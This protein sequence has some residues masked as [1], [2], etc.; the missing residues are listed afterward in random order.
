[1]VE[2]QRYWD[3]R[4]WRTRVRGWRGSVCEEMRMGCRTTF[5][6][7][8]VDVE[9]N[10]DRTI[11][12]VLSTANLVFRV[13]RRFEVEMLTT[14]FTILKT[15]GTS[16]W[17]L[18]GAMMTSVGVDSMLIRRTEEEAAVWQKWHVTEVAGV[19]KWLMTKVACTE[20]IL[21]RTG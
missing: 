16:K 20:L 4:D 1:M 13:S 9:G 3:W 12:E 8:V 15:F 6:V 19:K 2:N 21:S 7:L 14:Y 10:F 17:P 11:E 18:E 5:E